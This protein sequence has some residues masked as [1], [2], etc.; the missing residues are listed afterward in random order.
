MGRGL[1]DLQRNILVLA[2]NKRRTNAAKPEK[3]KDHHDLYY[4]EI[5]EQICGWRATERPVYQKEYQSRPG[6]VAT[7][8]HFSPTTIGEKKYNSTRAAVS[9]AIRRLRDRELVVWWQGVV[10]WSAID[11]TEAGMEKAKELE[12][13]LELENRDVE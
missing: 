11:L 3:L 10:K 5:F 6:A 8:W 13:L 9:R 7:G 4:A 1:S 12:A 2:L